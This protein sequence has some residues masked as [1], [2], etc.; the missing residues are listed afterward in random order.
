MNIKHRA[1]SAFRRQNGFGRY[2]TGENRDNQKAREANPLA[3]VA[4]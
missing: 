2:P 3:G 1:V 4:G